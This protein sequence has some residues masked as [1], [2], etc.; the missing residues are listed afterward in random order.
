MVGS[1]MHHCS[2]MCSRRF[3]RS[4]GTD[5]GKRARMQK[6]SKFG[7]AGAHDNAE[8]MINVLS[9]KETQIHMQE[10]DKCETMEMMA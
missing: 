3:A 7:G 6:T 4:V 1:V 5:C 9:T 8:M 10:C 2:S